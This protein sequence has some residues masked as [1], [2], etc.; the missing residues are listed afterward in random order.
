VHVA[1]FWKGEHDVTNAQFAKFVEA[2]GNVT[3][4]ERKPEWEELKKEL[5]W[6]CKAG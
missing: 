6:Y 5:P 3:T 4:A 1:G 2:T